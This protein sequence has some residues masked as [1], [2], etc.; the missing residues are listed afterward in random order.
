MDYESE[1]I[2]VGSREDEGSRAQSSV[3]DEESSYDDN[4]DA[5]I[6]SEYEIDDVMLESDVKET[7]QQTTTIPMR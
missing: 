4:D 7:Q 2:N 3:L 6:S 5:A 1:K